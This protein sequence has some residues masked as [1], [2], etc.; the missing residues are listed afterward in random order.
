MDIMHEKNTAVIET[1][2]DVDMISIR[3]SSKVDISTR[4]SMIIEVLSIDYQVV[5]PPSIVS[6]EP[7][8]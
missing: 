5:R 1:V 7:F 6:M 3:F 4:A 8:M 2:K